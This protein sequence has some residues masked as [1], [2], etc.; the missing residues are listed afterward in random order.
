MSLSQNEF[1]AMLDELAVYFSDNLKS[2][3]GSEKILDALLLILSDK[4]NIEWKWHILDID[5]QKE[6]ALKLLEE[7]DFNTL[8]QTIVWKMKQ[9]I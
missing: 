2:N 8:N 6:Q 5:I 4:E 9:Q 1:Y 3:I 7:F